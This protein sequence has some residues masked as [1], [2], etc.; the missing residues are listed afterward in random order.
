MNKP[1]AQCKYSSAICEQTTVVS[2]L[3]AGCGLGQSVFVA[4]KNR[5]R[6]R[7]YEAEGRLTI[8]RCESDGSNGYENGPV[9]IVGERKGHGGSASLAGATDVEDRNSEGSQGAGE[10]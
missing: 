2:C 8:V 7:L 3:K 10:I 6:L 5:G 9:E 4:R 1:L